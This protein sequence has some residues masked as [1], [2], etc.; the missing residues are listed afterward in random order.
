MGCPYIKDR[1]ALLRELDLGDFEEVERFPLRKGQ[2]DNRGGI[3]IRY[4]LKSKP[5][6]CVDAT[7]VG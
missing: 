6:S 4:A 7:N 2:L 5:L 3:E 1:G